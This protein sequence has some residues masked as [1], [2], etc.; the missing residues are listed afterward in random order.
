MKKRNY[1]HHNKPLKDFKKF[2]KCGIVFETRICCGIIIAIYSNTLDL[3]DPGK[4]T[5]PLLERLFAHW[6]T[7]KGI[8]LTHCNFSLA[9][10]RTIIKKIPS[11][12]YS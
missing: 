4:K 11:L 6:T 5:Q 2:Q 9:R 3:V 12:Q 1:K 10:D 8:K 7:C